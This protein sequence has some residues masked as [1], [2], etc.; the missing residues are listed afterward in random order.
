VEERE[1]G[2]KEAFG[3]SCRRWGKKKK[4]RQGEE[5]EEKMEWN[6]PKDLCVK[7]ENYR[8]LSIKHKFSLI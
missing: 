6:S 3:W 2:R 1:R 4:G 8:D 5:T 7:L